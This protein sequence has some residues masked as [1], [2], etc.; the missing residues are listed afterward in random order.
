MAGSKLY[1]IPE[2]ARQNETETKTLIDFSHVKV[3]SQATLENFEDEYYV[4]WMNKSFV[5]C[6]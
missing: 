2:I 3:A 4:L 5:I 1:V 6:S